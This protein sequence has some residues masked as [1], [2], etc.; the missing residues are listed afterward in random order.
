MKP[1]PKAGNKP[2]HHFIVRGLD[3]PGSSS[4]VSAIPAFFGHRIGAIAMQDA[5]IELMVV[6]EMLHTGDKGVL[7]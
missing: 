7:E 5:E 3:K 6:R 2:L 1:K 4:T